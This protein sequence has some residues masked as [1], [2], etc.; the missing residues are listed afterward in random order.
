M[1]R[2]SS[3]RPNSATLTREEYED[4]Y[5]ETRLCLSE[6]FS[7]GDAFVEASGKRMCIVGGV[8]LNDDEVL[9][10]WWGEELGEEDPAPIPSRHIHH[11]LSLDQ[12]IANRESHQPSSTY[13][14]DFLP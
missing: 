3:H 1:Q 8:P 9:A 4:V 14:A 7:V 12:S 5:G 11:T 6:Q 13:F 10:Q 2:L